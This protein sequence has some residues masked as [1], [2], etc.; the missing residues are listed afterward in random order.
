[1]SARTAT[2]TRLPT[3]A[4]VRQERQLRAKWEREDALVRELAVLRA[5]I[6]PLQREVSL[7]RGF[8]FTVS[9]EK[10]EM[11]ERPRPVLP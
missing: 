9:R 2:V 3:D 4:K 6:R 5:D 10:L 11:P 8:L 7:A 1:M